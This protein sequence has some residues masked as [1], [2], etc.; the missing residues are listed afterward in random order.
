MYKL[1]I[2]FI[3]LFVPSNLSR[4]SNSRSRNKENIRNT[5]SKIKQDFYH[6][7]KIFLDEVGNTG[8]RGWW[9]GQTEV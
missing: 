4:D 2:Y 1:Y 3:N 7:R 6:G 9:I 8:S 5:K